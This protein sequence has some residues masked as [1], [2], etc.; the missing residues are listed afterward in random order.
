MMFL[1]ITGEANGKEFSEAH[2]QLMKK[3]ESLQPSNSIEVLLAA[4]KDTYYRD[5]EFELRFRVSLDSY[6]ILMHISTEGDITFFT[7][8]YQMDGKVK[9]GKVYSTKTDL[10]LNVT[11][12]PPAGIETIN[13]FCSTE[14]ID[15]F[16]KELDENNKFYQIRHDDDDSLAALAKSLE[17]LEQKDLDW[18]GSG[19]VVSIVI[20]DKP[21]EKPVTRALPGAIPPIS[22]TG[23]SG[24]VVPPIGTTGT[25]GKD[26]GVLFPPLGTT[27]TTG[28]SENP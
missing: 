1:W 3:L 21:D 11:A 17:K 9:A 6:V 14:K 12:I 7:P 24:L 20:P 27:G 10:G 23:T 8:N 19:L 2:N 5:N 18:S 22:T 4:D 25:A 28:H 26:R 13:L 16:E 15:L